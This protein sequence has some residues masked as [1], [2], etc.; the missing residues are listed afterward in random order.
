MQDLTPSGKTIVETADSAIYPNPEE[1]T[2]TSALWKS[3]TTPTNDHSERVPF[4]AAY[5][6]T[7]Q[8]C[9]ERFP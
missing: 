3:A 9:S 6:N 8:L 7:M 2:A 1:V 4:V 5:P